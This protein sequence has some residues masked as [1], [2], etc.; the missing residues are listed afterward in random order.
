MKRL[1][2]LFL[3][4]T[5]FA[6]CTKKELTLDEKID[7]VKIE[8]DKVKDSKSDSEQKIILT[9]SLFGL[10]EKFANEF[11][12]EERSPLL[13]FKIAEYKN[14]KGFP[15]VGAKTY[16]TFQERYPDHKEAAQALMRSAIIF[17]GVIN[18]R[19]HSKKVYQ[20]IIDNYPDS[21]EAED[22]KA[23]LAL[24]NSDKSLEEIIDEFEKKN[25]E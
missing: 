21:K 10:Y 16:E 15:A 23:N 14:S 12:E 18:D 5:I 2:I 17:E 6:S 7:L 9:D 13:L 19:V 22:A 1:L 3:A 24:M 11:P 20:R 8:L 25:Q 4:T